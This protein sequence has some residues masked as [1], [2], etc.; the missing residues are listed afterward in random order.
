MRHQ[1]LIQDEKR[2]VGLAQS[3]NLPAAQDTIDEIR[4][5]DEGEARAADFAVSQVK[6]PEFAE[7]DFDNTRID[8]TY[9]LKVQE[10][11]KHQ[12]LRWLNEYAEIR[13]F[14]PDQPK[15]PAGVGAPP[16][17][18]A[19]ARTAGEIA[20]DVVSDVGRGIVEAP[21]QA[22]GGI[23]DAVT[24]MLPALG[25]FTQSIAPF[26]FSGLPGAGG[27]SLTDEDGNFAPSFDI[28][29][30]IGKAVASVKLPTTE[31]GESVTGGAVRGISQFLTGFAAASKLIGGIK[32]TG[33][34]V[35]AGMFADFAAFD[36]HEQRLSDLVQSVP[37]LEN[38]VT[39]FLASDAE[40]SQIVGRLK[41]V[42]EGL[43]GDAVFAG[44]L[45][46]LRA[47]KEANRLRAETGGETFAQAAERAA[48]DTLGADLPALRGAD[49]LTPLVGDPT[50]P[51]LEIRDIDTGVPDDITARAA[52][53]EGLSRVE[54]GNR[55]VFINFARIN[56][57]ED[58]KGLIGDMADAFAGD[59]GEAARGVRSN[60]QTIKAAGDENAWSLISERRTGQP[61]NAEQTFAVRSLWAA[62]AESLSKLAQNATRAPNPE[63]LF[64]FRRAFALHSSIQKE[65][66]A[67][68]T[69]TARA[70]Q[71]W[72]IPAGGAKENFRDLESIID[73]HGG[74]G[75]AEDMARRIALLAEDG[76]HGAID[77]M[78]RKSAFSTT[79]DAVFSYWINGLLSG[80]KTHMVNMMSNSGVVLLSVLER[81]TA[82]GIGD[83]L[84]GSSRTQRGE[85]AAM[86][87]G[88]IGSAR[89]AF[90]NAGR[91]MR[92]GETGFGVQKL[93]GPRVQAIS[94]EILGNTSNDT[95]NKIVN[96]SVTAR[97]IDAIGTIISIPGRALGAE[98]EFFKTGNYRMEVHAQALR[99][100]SQE[101]EAGVIP[102]SQ[103]KER[104]A[105]LTDN[106]PESVR[107]AAADFAAYNTFTRDPGEIVKR[108]MS[109]KGKVPFA[110]YIVPFINTPANILKFTFERTPFA[111]LSAKYR[112]D[113]AAGGT[114]RDGALARVA[115]GSTIMLTASDLAMNGFITGSGPDD[116]REI[117]ELRRTGWQPYSIK[118]GDR[119]FAYNRLDPVGTFLGIGA[120]LSEYAMNSDEDPNSEYEEVAM[121]S[122]LAAGENMMEKTYLRG[123]SDLVGALNDP[124]RFGPAYFERFAGSFVP[125]IVGEVTR[126]QDPYMKHATS[127]VQKLK[128]RLPGLSKDVPN[129][130]DL[131][132]RPISF[133]SGLGSAYDAISPI[134]SSEFKPEPADLELD[135]LGYFP[136]P[137]GKNLGISLNGKSETISLRNSPKIFQRYVVLGGG[138]SAA[139][140]G[141]P[142][143]K[144]G[145]P[146]SISR[147]LDSYGNKTALEF[148]NDLVTNS[149]EFAAMTDEDKTDTIR[150]VLADYRA[151]A[152]EKLKEEFPELMELRERMEE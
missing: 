63:N 31:K 28:N 78:A 87:H 36:G 34:A 86:L 48:L 73:V 39:E 117:Q 62:S 41:N 146:N 119:Y 16:E 3:G 129:R 13:D 130:H 112:S 29:Q 83:F 53:P 14:E 85:A 19:P 88:L 138:T 101:V 37:E 132:G 35:G 141:R 40:D 122:V 6:R 102:R 56:S 45:N 103:F 58:I 57:T 104:L 90:V 25:D 68:R 72:A 147:K 125:S 49:T 106:P 21:L 150:T 23:S 42:V 64:A 76:N 70:L 113:I 92:T 27:L 7:P 133:R 105:E 61:M 26:A 79:M 96:G 118:V 60:E 126:Q 99:T 107:I 20:M 30:E 38:P 95:F 82:E 80:P 121:Q 127:I 81:A 66:I 110:R 55:E 94:S 136:G 5:I 123:F 134:Y 108:I 46:G 50:K 120:D 111:P 140:L 18:P 59:I 75:V 115:V 17:A 52:T 131:W 4:G 145:K 69:E 71:Q 1:P 137:P 116:F 91:S 93:E 24:A 12:T 124:Q 128:S 139:E 148:I 100:A 22:L 9:S 89:D 151:G 67:V 32:T 74:A 2:A 15:A 11:E 47:V 152:R 51:A 109:M 143:T 54:V 10:R 144:A 135:R 98:D 97:A 43:G 142:L 114:R 44:F 8:E 33:Q 149:A 84:Q 65:V 77:Y